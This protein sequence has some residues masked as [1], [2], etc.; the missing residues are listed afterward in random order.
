MYKV[1]YYPD[2]IVYNMPINELY[3]SMIKIY[4]T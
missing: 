2:Y 4:D 1:R 3:R